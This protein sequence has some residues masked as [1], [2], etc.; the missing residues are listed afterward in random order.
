MSIINTSEVQKKISYYESKIDALRQL[1]EIS[2]TLEGGTRGRAREKKAGKKK[3]K[4][5]RRG[6]R[7]AVSNAVIAMLETA[8]RPLTAGEI[9]A[10]LEERKLAKKGSSSVYS[11]L[12]QMSKRGVLKKVKTAKGRGYKLAARETGERQAAGK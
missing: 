10:A 6:K 9:K 12:L 5:A 8:T 3:A 7:G 2:K 1:L 4:P 11:T